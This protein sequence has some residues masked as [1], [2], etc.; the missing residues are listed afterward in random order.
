LR[1]LGYWLQLR[2]PFDLQPILKGELLELR[3]LRAEDY[4]ALF[5]VASDPLIWEQHPNRD[6]YKEEVFKIFFREALERG[7]ALIA[8]DAKTGQ[9][10]GSSRFHG[11]DQV[12]S[13]VEIGWTF[14]ARS[15]WGGLYNGEM[16]RLMLQ[17]AFKFVARVVFLIGEHN[18]RSRRAVEKIGAACVGSRHRDGQDHVVYQILKST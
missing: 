13:E 18:L 8:T 11:Y 17:H 1:T 16:K 3:P 5:T 2:M 14:L 6:R 12:T 15:H 7:G 4:A 9:V 10:I